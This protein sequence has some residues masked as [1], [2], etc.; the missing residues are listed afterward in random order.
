MNRQNLHTLLLLGLFGASSAS[1]AGSQSYQCSITEET[2]LAAN[3]QMKPYPKP[4]ALGKRFAIDR[5][6]GALAEPDLAFWAPT[7][8][9]VTVLAKGNKDNSFVATY[10]AQ[11]AKVGVH[12]TVV[13]VE[14]FAPT[15]NKPFLVV[16]GASIYSGLCE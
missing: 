9:V 2:H 12:S 1:V 11:A 10:V 14:E 15:A 5:N 3:G 7:D 8:A 16:S 4:L 13:R 6:S